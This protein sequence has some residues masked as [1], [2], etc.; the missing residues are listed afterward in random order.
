MLEFAV[1]AAVFGLVAGVNPG[2]LGIVVIH[3]TL[4]NGLAAGLRA[5]L[6]PLI[7]DGAIIAFVLLF[8]KQVREIDTFVSVV[9]ILGSLFLLVM[10]VKMLRQRHNR[11]GER[12]SG[13]QSIATAVKVN[14][15]SPNPYIFWFTVGGA[16]ILRGSPA[17]VLVFVSVAIGTLVLTKMATAVMTHWFRSYITGDGYLLVS[18]FLAVALIVFSVQLFLQGVDLIG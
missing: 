17:E 14:L 15:L 4:E 12:L 2:P 18:K 9:S 11:L 8:Q 13:A 6:A 7:T 3:Q 10:A 16:Y 1:A 5:S